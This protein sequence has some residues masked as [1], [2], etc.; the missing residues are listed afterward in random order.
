MQ[1]KARVLKKVLPALPKASVDKVLTIIHTALREKFAQKDTLGSV[2]IDTNLSKCPVPL[3]QRSTSDTLRALAR[4][5]RLPLG[6]KNTL[7]MFV[8]W[9]GKDIDLSC[10]LYDKAFN[11]KGNI[12]YTNLKIQQINCCHSGDITNA[13][14]GAAEFIDIDIAQAV[15]A[16]VRYITMNVLDY[17]GL[18]FSGYNECYAGWMTR[19]Y[20][21]NNEIYDPKTAEQKID[22]RAPSR[23]ATPVLFDLVNREA[24]WLDLNGHVK[25]SLPNNVESN[26]A[27]I[28]EF[29]QAALLLSDKV[30][31][32]DLFKLHADARGELVEAKEDADTIFSLDEGVTPFDIVKISSEYVA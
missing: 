10:V 26:A 30:N 21:N 25:S 6:D 13:P 31:L 18:K 28:L 29:A 24:V 4:G 12:S 20:P 16:G 11:K 23:L 5:T 27:T 32:Y 15:Q 7:R 1:S 9:V 8:W 14:N 22:L 2:W 19:D 3:A 17:S